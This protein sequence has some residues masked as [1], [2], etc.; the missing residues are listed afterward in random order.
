MV[1]FSLWLHFLK[2]TFA[3]NVNANLLGVK[4]V[5]TCFAHQLTSKA[6]DEHLAWW[7][8]GPGIPEKPECTHQPRSSLVLSL[9]YPGF[10]N[11]TWTLAASS[12]FSIYFKE[13]HVSSPPM[14]SLLPLLFIFF[15][16]LSQLGKC[17]EDKKLDLLFYFSQSCISMKGT[18]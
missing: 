2:Y 12:Y 7:S 16:R 6:S 5:F 11:S 8:P 3:L 15:W 10:F 14:W 9:S 1:P 18:L 17:A 13:K 4:C